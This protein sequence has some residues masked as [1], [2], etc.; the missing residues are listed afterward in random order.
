MKYKDFFPDNAEESKWVELYEKQTKI[1]SDFLKGIP[2]EDRYAIMKQEGPTDLSLQ[3]LFLYSLKH[4]DYEICDVA[5]K[6]LK[7]RVI[8]FKSD[9]W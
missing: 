6:L 9:A 1:I 2:K 5:N 3:N 8:E 4:E 7:E